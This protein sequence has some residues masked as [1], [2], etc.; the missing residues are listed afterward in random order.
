MKNVNNFQITKVQPQGG[1]YHLLNFCQFQP[2]EFFFFV[3][4]YCYWW[5]RRKQKQGG[6]EM[7]REAVRKMEKN[8]IIII[9]AFLF[10]LCLIGQNIV[11][12]HLQNIYIENF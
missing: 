1:A 3:V 8:S 2:G 10:G 9:L 7:I 6:E 12:R 5:N 4:F 11:I